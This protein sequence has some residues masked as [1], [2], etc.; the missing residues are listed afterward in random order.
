MTT[1]L[2]LAALAAAGIYWATRPGDPP[3]QTRESSNDWVTRAPPISP[4]RM[5]IDPDRDFDWISSE[6]GNETCEWNMMEAT[7]F[8][9]DGG[10]KYVVNVDAGKKEDAVFSQ[11]Y[12]SQDQ[13]VVEA[14]Q[15][16]EGLLEKLTARRR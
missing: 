3:P 13:A 9:Q 10:W 5:A 16:M 14:E 11:R 12:R 15:Y 1:F 6:N 2:I 7:V 4:P 8:E